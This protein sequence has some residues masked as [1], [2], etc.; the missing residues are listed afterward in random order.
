MLFERNY[1]L[2]EEREMWR[3]VEEAIEDSKPGLLK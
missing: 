3:E 2:A 1:T